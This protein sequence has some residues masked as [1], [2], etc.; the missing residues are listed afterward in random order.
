MSV[1]SEN[2]LRCKAEGM[3][4][5]EIIEACGCTKA[6]L[7]LVT[8]K[9]KKISNHAVWDEK[10]CKEWRVVTGQILRLFAAGVPMP[11]YYKE[12]RRMNLERGTYENCK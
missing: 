2:I 5:E 9:R 6:F 10:R 4:D 11:E 3:S 7:E 8:G 1:L 12:V